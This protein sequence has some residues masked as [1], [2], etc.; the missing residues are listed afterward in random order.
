MKRHAAAFL[1]SIVASLASALS[2]DNGASPSLFSTRERAQ[3]VVVNGT[4]TYGAYMRVEIDNDDTSEPKGMFFDGTYN[5]TGVGTLP[6]TIWATMN[7]NQSGA[8]D[9]AHGGA[10]FGR[11]I[12]GVAV[13]GFMFGVE[14]NA[15]G[16][17]TSTDADVVGVI[18]HAVWKG[19]DSSTPT[20]NIIGMN[21]R[22]EV[23]TADLS[24]ARATGTIIGVRSE[25]YGGE[26]T[27]SFYGVGVANKLVNEGDVIKVRK[28][29][30]ALSGGGTVSTV[31]GCG[32]MIVVTSTGIISTGAQA[33]TA[34][35][36]TVG[37]NWNDGCEIT[38]FN[39]NLVAGRNITFKH[40][41]TNLFTT[42]SADIVVGPYGGSFRAGSF[43]E[44]SVWLQSTTVT[45]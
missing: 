3:G 27:Y 36:S 20:A 28:P 21:A 22:A 5:G 45:K 29:T 32:G 10:I 40:S 37:A 1:F 25:V 33:L 34:P 17:S 41:G 7:Y 38:I 15:W 26:N 19:A 39:G 43:P 18:A 42:T 35:S 13:Q 23:T 12:G 6:A 2:Y 44:A 24:T 4:D 8:V 31:G 14:G 11:A 16:T 9:T 30:Q